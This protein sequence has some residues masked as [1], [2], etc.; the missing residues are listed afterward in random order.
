MANTK[1]EIFFG[2]VDNN[3]AVVGSAATIDSLVQM[4]Q[5]DKYAFTVLH[6]GSQ[7]L[8][9]AVGVL[10]LAKATTGLIP[11][12]NMV[13]NSWAG[14]IAFLKITLDL[15]NPMGRINSGDVLTLIGNGINIV[16]SIRVLA[17][18][19]AGML[20]G[21]G[22]IVTMAPW[23]AP[24]LAENIYNKIISPIFNTYFINSPSATYPDCR[25]SPDLTLSNPQE[26][27][28]LYRNEIAMCMWD[29]TNNA[30]QVGKTNAKNGAEKADP[31]FPRGFPDNPDPSRPRTGVGLPAQPYPPISQVPAAPLVPVATGGNVP[32]PVSSLP[33]VS[34]GYP[35]PSVPDGVVITRPPILACSQE[36]LLEFKC[37]PQP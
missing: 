10:S 19:G 36:E 31:K 12:A 3:G 16:A 9:S 15:R 14:T 22:V 17:G 34:V 37:G 6:Q 5:E 24:V 18:F 26:I 7:A 21:V 27:A 8:S 35:Q 25:I 2:L 13:S 30:V 29:Y 11:F 32:V 1:L 20:G 33:T 23:F 4:F 28:V